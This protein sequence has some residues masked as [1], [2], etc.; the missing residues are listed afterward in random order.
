MTNHKN[1]YVPMEAILQVVKEKEDEFFLVLN[2][3]S[4]CYLKVFPWT[5]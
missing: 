1:C 4:S 2:F 3:V 5:P